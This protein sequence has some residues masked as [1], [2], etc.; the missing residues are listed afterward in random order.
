MREQITEQYKRV[1]TEVREGAHKAWLLGLGTY[2]WVGEEGKNL[3]DASGKFVGDLVDR[4]KKVEAKGKKELGKA[5]KDAEKEAKSLR[6]RVEKG[7]EDVGEQV[8][9][10]VTE[11]LHRVG[12]PTRQEIHTLTRRVEELTARLETKLAAGAAASER[13]VYHVATHDDGWKIE[14]E[15][16]KRA[17]STHATKD[18]AVDAARTLAQNN[19]P[20]QVVVHRMD[21]TIQNN[22]SYDVAS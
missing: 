9:K 13:K 4:G 12:I 6:N 11:V 14:V 10:R 15:G 22:Y 20:S 16:A 18:E 2:S 5:K 7:F 19:E 21:G 1:E 3:I 17:T 8:D